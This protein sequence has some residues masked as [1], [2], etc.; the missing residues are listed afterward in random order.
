M[1]T[2]TL[3]EALRRLAGLPALLR[4]WVIVRVRARMQ[5]LRGEGND[6]HKTA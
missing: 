1:A 4:W 2:V 3:I 5:R 6:E